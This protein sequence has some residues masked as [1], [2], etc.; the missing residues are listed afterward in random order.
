[1]AV[2][3]ALGTIQAA[4]ARVFPADTPHSIPSTALDSRHAALQNRAVF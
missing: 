2:L 1:L 4:G 3:Q